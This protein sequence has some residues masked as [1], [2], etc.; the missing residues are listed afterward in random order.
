MRNRF[1]LTGVAETKF[2]RLGGLAAALINNWQLSSLVILSGGFAFNA[3]TGAD[4]N[5]DSIF[6]DRP[7]GAA[8]NAY[9]L[10]GYVTLDMRLSRILPLGEKMRLELIG[11]GFNLTNRLNPTGVNRVFGPNAT[12]NANFNAV[13]SAETARQFQLAARFSF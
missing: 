8:Y 10:P 2:A 11:E 3:T 9:T 13:T 6:N 1:T 12:P 7:S 5:G 4:T